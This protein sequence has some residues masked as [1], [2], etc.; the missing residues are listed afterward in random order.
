[1]FAATAINFLLSSVVTGTQ[2]AVFIGTIRKVLILDTDYPL[3]GKL[4]LVKK[5][6]WNLDIVIDWAGTIS[7]ST[8]L[9]RP[10]A[11]TNDTPTSRSY[12]ATSS[13]FGGPGPSLKIDDG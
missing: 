11:V 2:V 1:M 9:P 12:S 10:D 3:S 5:V 7:V 4:E 6:V 8:N 13:S